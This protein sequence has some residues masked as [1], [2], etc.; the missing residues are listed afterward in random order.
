MIWLRYLVN[1]CSAALP[2]VNKNKHFSRASTSSAVFYGDRLYPNDAYTIA[3]YKFSG[4]GGGQVFI[5]LAA[6]FLIFGGS[7][8][9]QKNFQQC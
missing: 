4:F 3:R 6:A 8:F 7:S 9:E 1:A 2:H 5:F